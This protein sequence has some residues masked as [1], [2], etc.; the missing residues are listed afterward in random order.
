MSVGDLLLGHGPPISF[1]GFASL[2]IDS[3]V[4]MCVQPPLRTEAR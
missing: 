1:K 2:I 3:D 4:G